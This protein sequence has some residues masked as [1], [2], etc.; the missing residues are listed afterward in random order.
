MHTKLKIGAAIGFIV[1]VAQVGAQVSI[2]SL[3]VA[4]VETFTGYTGAAAP[5]GWTI[6]SGEVFKGYG[7]GS[8]TAGGVYSFGSDNTG[9]STDRWLGFQF[10][11]SPSDAVTFSI[12]YVNDTGVTITSLDVSMDY[13]QFRLASGGRESFFTVNLDGGSDI[14]ELGFTSTTTGTTGFQSPV[15]ATTKS[16]TLTGLNI[17]SGSTFSFNIVGNRGPTTGSAQGI[18]ID[19][20]SV[21]ASAVPEPSTYAAI[22]GAVALAGA[23]VVRRRKQVKA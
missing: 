8:D 22:A 21:T 14:S 17:A 10:A 7:K 11:G 5:S 4:S 12:S 9:A 18:G 6:S 15:T 23:M 1:F 13:F 3:G 16:V 20:F 19:N 2:P